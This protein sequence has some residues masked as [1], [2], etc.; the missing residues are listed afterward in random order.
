VAWVEQ[1]GRGSWRV[2]YR[3]DDATIGA[4]KGF[5]TKAAATAHAHTLE[6]EQRHGTWIDPA[7]GKITLRDWTTDWLDAL[8]VAIRTEDYYRSLLSCHILPRWGETSLT[9][10]SGV[11][12]AAWA[13]QLR[14][15]YAPV[16]VTGITKLLGLLL[17]DAADERLIPANPIRTHRRGRHR[18]TRTPERMWA[19]HEQAL[20]LADNAA[21]LPTAGTAAALLLVTAAWTGARWGELAGLHR[22]HTHLDHISDHG[23]GAIGCIVIDPHH[24]ALIESSRGLELGP[25]KTVESART[26][27]LP[28]FLTQLLREHLHTHDQPQVFPSPDGGFH[29]R[30]NFSRRV[31]R[32]AAD[33]TP[34]H[35]DPDRRLPAVQP[36]L[37]FHGLRHSHK[38]WMIAD[39]VPEIAQAHRLGHTLKDKIQ[40]TYSHVATEVDTR[41][42]QAL[43]DRWDKAVAHHGH[44]P[45]WRSATDT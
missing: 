40:Q 8:D 42:L 6:A 35:P 33:G 25:P 16:T 13:K 19:T 2:R 26:I 24:G 45:A 14:T 12:V 4:I 36:G 37:T 11:H 29:R 7:A 20:A 43:Q 28:P 32:P 17:T 5:A 38:T 18:H 34:T 27:A 1:S 15:A 3:R 41:L 39:G 9:D 10:I 22:H 23:D 21:Q 31:M 44:T 30:S